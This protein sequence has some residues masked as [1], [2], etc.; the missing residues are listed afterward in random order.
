MKKLNIKLLIAA[1]VAFLVCYPFFGADAK[2]TYIKGKVE[3][4]RNGQWVA[5]SVGDT[6]S[7]SETINTGFQSEARLNINGSVLAVPALTRVTLETLSTSES[8]DKVSLYVNTGSVRSKV[9]HTENKKIDYTARTAVAVAS[10]RGTDFTISAKG[11]VSCREGAVAVYSAK[12]FNKMMQELAKQEEEAEEESEESVAEESSDSSTAEGTTEETAASTEVADAGTD[13]TEASANQDAGT[14]VA[15]A[16][17]TTTTTTETQ[18]EAAQP[19]AT[20]TTPARDI[21]PTAPTGT[22]V[23][24]AGQSTTFTPAG[25]PEKP[26]TDASQKST[27]IKTQVT[28][29]GEKSTE[30]PDTG[31]TP[32][33]VVTNEP[34]KGTLIVTVTLEN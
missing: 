31:S 13:T 7:Q 19:P 30:T 22:V 25:N 3:V 5:L 24:G 23:V 11:A 28:T 1:F 17:A 12:R 15:V 14:E 6:I 4:S 21:T 20:S 27:K 34:K 9:T 16:P 29:M 10:V 33:V 8:K 2:V 32:P 26:Q 18:P